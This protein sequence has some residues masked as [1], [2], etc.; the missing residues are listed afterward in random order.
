MKSISPKK[1]KTSLKKANFVQQ[2]VA[3]L[4]GSGIQNGGRDPKL[5]GGVSA[6]Y[7]LEEKLYP[8]LYSEITG[9]AVSTFMFLYHIHKKNSFLQR[10]SSAA[11]WLLKNALHTDGGLKTRLYL[12]KH[13]VSPNY[14]FDQGRIYSFDT[15]IVGYGLLQLYKT[16]PK[17]EYLQ[18]VQRILYF[19]TRRMRKK[20][21]DFYPYFDPIKKKC[22]EDLGKWSDQAGS[23]HAKLALLFIDY[24]RLTG[25]EFYRKS[26][27]DLLDVVKKFQQRD[28][29][30]IT[31]KKDDSTHLHPH[32]YT[33]E[34]LLYGGVHLNRE[35]YISACHKGFQWMLNG[36]SSDGSVSSI[37]VGRSFSH[38]ERS[39]IV[40]Q[41]LR[42]GSM[43]Y[44]LDHKKFNSHL[45]SLE[46]V[47]KHLLLFQN[48]IRGC[49][50]GGFLYGSATDGLVRMHLNSWSTMFAIQ[51]LW[52]HDEFVQN[53]KPLWLESFV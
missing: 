5:K 44:A 2:A 16:D 3:W 39:D 40:A 26:A 20:G 27:I 7:E 14:S 41:V 36:I 48:R 4:L 31:G 18:A 11:E 23:F 35:D 51:A 46:E 8:F 17:L 24:H 10:A 34:G 19:L 30:F 33:L 1:N 32:A 13:Y 53:K 38:H 25:D 21:G 15:A 49:Q 12:V 9:Y 37:Y 28:G 6:W 52:M 42:L 47:K 43:L 22:G 45:P 29:R 50:A